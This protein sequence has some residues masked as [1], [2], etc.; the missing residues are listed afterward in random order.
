MRRRSTTTYINWTEYTVL[1]DID[2]EKLK[3]IGAICL[4]WNFIEDMIDETLGRVLQ[5]N[6]DTT[7]DVT[8]RINGLDGKFAIIKRSADISP[9]FT[10][11]EIERIKSTIGAIAEHKSYRDAVIHARVADPKSDIAL[12][13]KRRGVM[14]EILLSTDVLKAIS[15]RLEVVED[16]MVA[17]YRLLEARTY[18]EWDLTPDGQ[19]DPKKVRASQSFRHE[20]SQLRKHQKRRLDLPPLPKFPEAPSTLQAKVKPK[21]IP[22]RS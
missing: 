11:R 15:H 10:K 18:N 22:N 17:L 16:E 13:R 14:E 6:F 12:Y 2:P 19:I 7:F 5:L 9:F 1:E 8:S 21:G 3:F 4:Q 20:I